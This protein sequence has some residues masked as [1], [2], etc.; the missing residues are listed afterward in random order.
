MDM[1]TACGAEVVEVIEVV[2]TDTTGAL[3][4]YRQWLIDP[5]GVEVVNPWIKPSRKRLL[6]RAEAKL[7]GS[8]NAMRFKAAR[9]ALRVV[10]RCAS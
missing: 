9:P 5:D 2:A 4:I 1:A 3:A 6:F 7:R 10:D 8:L